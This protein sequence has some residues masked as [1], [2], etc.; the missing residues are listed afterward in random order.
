MIF[1]DFIIIIPIIWFAYK[2]FSKGLV[3]GI[4]SLVAL[5]LGTWV[6]VNFSNILGDFI[7]IEGP[8][9]D[10]I[11][12]ILTFVGV[13]FGVYI[14]AKAIEKVVSITISETANKLLGALFGAFKI[15]FILSVIFKFIL[16]FDH[17]EMFLK[18][19]VKEN[20]KLLPFIQP[21]APVVLPAFR[22]AIDTIHSKTNDKSETESEDLEND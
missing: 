2:G 19:K 21:I 16:S 5:V 12:F 4:A 17:H 6:A 13:L 11:F 22:N 15:A 9:V 18:A 3:F 20:S 10:I 14:V 8:Y 1:L 7:N